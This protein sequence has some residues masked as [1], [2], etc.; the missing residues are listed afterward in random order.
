M[1]EKKRYEQF[2]ELLRKGMEGCTQRE[3]ADKIGM[4]TEH[5]NRM[6]N[7]T[8]IGKP[9]RNTLE[10]MAS[11]MTQVSLSDLLASCGYSDAS[12]DYVTLDG[13]VNSFRW[14]LTCWFSEFRYCILESMDSFLNEWAKGAPDFVTVKNLGRVIFPEDADIPEEYN[15]AECADLVSISWDASVQTIVL[16][17]VILYQKT[18]RGRIVPRE[19]SF[20]GRDV[21]SHP[22]FPLKYRKQMEHYGICPEYLP[23]V[24]VYQPFTSEQTVDYVMEHMLGVGRKF[25]TTLEGFGFYLDTEIDQN[26]LL[27]WLKQHETLL[28]GDPDVWTGYTQMLDGKPY[29]EAFGAFDGPNNVVPGW[30]GVIAYVLS[31]LTG[32]D[33]EYFADEND[34]S[35]SSCV[36]CEGLV[37]LKDSIVEP[38]YASAKTLG[39]PYIQMVYFETILYED[40]N[41]RIAVE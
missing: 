26:C 14:K 4:S 37:D 16:Y 15:E 38:V 3:F 39:I 35:K 29:Q 31:Q 19:V 13:Q 8:Y 11:V 12:Q 40:L 2:R 34:P 22:D 30:G 25:V 33:F 17:A 18:I 7:Q 20:F 21:C 24:A 27:T 6:L 28:S 36:M 10:R 41:S 9:A 1:R 23:Y 32:Q 5:L